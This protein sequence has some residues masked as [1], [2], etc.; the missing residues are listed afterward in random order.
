MGIGVPFEV[1]RAYSGNG[2]LCKRLNKQL[3]H[4][5]AEI[6]EKEMRLSR[7]QESKQLALRKPNECL[8]AKNG[9]ENGNQDG[10]GL[11]FFR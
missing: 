1:V 8:K 2:Y 4:R 6:T 5:D 11:R 7:T 9:G 10:F 3:Q